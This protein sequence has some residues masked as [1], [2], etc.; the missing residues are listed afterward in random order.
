MRWTDSFLDQLRNQSDDLADTHLI[1]LME[2]SEIQHI[3]EVFKKLDTNTAEPV[4]K[5]FPEL[6][7]FYKE[8]HKLPAGIDFARI[9]RGEKA[10]ARFAFPA[11]L[12]MLTKSLPEGYA[13]PNLAQV[14]NI[15][16][17]LERH[18]YRRLLQVLQMLLNVCAVHGFEDGGRAVIT[19]QKLRLLHAGI[20]HIA[21]QYLPDY[22]KNY[23]IVVNH[24]D[25]L[26][27][28]MGFSLLVLKGLR[29]LNCNMTAQEEED[30]FYIWRVYAVMMGIYPPDKPDA[31]DYIPDSVTDAEL[32]YQ[33]YARRHYRNAVDNPDGVQL[34]KANVKMLKKL[35][36]FW[37]KIFG[38]GFAPQV[39]TYHLLGKEAAAR[40][41]INRVAAHSLLKFWLFKL[42]AV[43]NI[44]SGMGE[45]SSHHYFAGLVFQKMI[46]KKFGHEITFT[47]PDSLSQV[48][49]MVLN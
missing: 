7:D 27:T 16:K 4:H 15:S 28:I 40:V 47:V 9:D 17:N 38:F 33:A 19:A 26:A 32:F 31:F 37:L 3:S 23:H 18:P 14:L 41:G 11:A 39:Y 35:V 1:K 10:F 36:P 49:Q 44:F 8:T 2:D 6:D 12:V 34:T 46:N 5:L 42:P 25:M 45:R 24:E 48:K 13:A 20:R 21:K 30:F 43:I 22:A 29:T